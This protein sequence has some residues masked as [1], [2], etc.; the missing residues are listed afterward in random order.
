MTISGYS[1]GY[2]THALEYE[3]GVNLNRRPVLRT[4]QEL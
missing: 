3:S 2:P 4:T 1:T